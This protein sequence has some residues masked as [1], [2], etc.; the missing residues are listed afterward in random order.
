MQNSNRIHKILA[1][2]LVAFSLFTLVACGGQANDKDYQSYLPPPTAQLGE[3]VQIDPDTVLTIKE[4]RIVPG[5]K[6]RE[7]LIISYDWKNISGKAKVSQEA[8]LITAKQN[9]TV[10]VGDLSQVADKT[11]LVTQVK[12]GDSLIGIEQGFILNSRD[13]VKLSLAGKEH[14][15]FI[16]GKPNPAYPVTVDLELE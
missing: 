2:L 1:L 3:S 6:D 4:T 5:D 15:V 8:Y 10:L 7:I 16:D 9:G 11:K 12:D 14:T 13:P